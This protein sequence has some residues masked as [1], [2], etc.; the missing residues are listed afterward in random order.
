VYK[1]KDYDKKYVADDRIKMRE[2]KKDNI[3]AS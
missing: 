2:N 1:W 3:L